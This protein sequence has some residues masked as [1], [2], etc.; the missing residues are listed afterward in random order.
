[1]ASAPARMRTRY[2]IDE[3]KSLG[4]ACSNRLPPASAVQA[5]FLY[6]MQRQTEIERLFH[7]RMFDMAK[8]EDPDDSTAI[9]MQKLEAD[10]KDLRKHMDANDLQERL[11]TSQV[12]FTAQ[13]AK[14]D[15]CDAKSALQD[16]RIATLETALANVNTVKTANP[17]PTLVEEAVS[18]DLTTIQA[19]V[20]A[21]YGERDALINMHNESNARIQ[22]LEDLVRQLTLQM[23]IS[24]SP[25]SASPAMVQRLPMQ[26]TNGQAIELTVPRVGGLSSGKENRVPGRTFTPGEPWAR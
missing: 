13:Q 16:Q 7:S 9:R 8:A 2:T 21:L 4:R 6:E 14:I 10:L 24:N 3:L 22:K 1:M 12:R 18:N 5:M 15:A 17:D 11:A 19:D 20:D 26:N 23:S 25:S